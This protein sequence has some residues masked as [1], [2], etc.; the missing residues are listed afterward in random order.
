MFCID[1]DKLNR[2]IV[3]RATTKEAI[4]DEI[5]IDRSTFYRRLKNGKLLIGD[6]HKMCAVL[7]LSSS[8]AIEIFLA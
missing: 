7:Q 5:G 2:K 4:A 1:L 3:E 6:I 8:E